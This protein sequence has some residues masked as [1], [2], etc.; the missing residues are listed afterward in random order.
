MTDRSVYHM[1]NSSPL[2]SKTNDDWNAHLASASAIETDYE[3]DDWDTL[4]L[5]IQDVTPLFSDPLGLAVLVSDH[6][7]EQLEET[8][9]T[10][11]IDTTHVYR[12]H[13]DSTHYLIIVAEASGAHQ[14]IIIPAYLHNKQYEKLHQLTDPDNAIHTTIRSLGTD[15]RVTITHDDPT[16]FF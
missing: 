11:A 4:F 12:N 13:T 15:A 2:P 8:V 7:F 5:D 16:V 9:E 10:I 6:E 14:A 1:G 3:N